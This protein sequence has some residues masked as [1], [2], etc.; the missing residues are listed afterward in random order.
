MLITVLFSFFDKCDK[1]FLRDNKKEKIFSLFKLV[2]LK[3]HNC[4]LSCYFLA[5]I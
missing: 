5:V 1:G 2:R 4:Y 3:S